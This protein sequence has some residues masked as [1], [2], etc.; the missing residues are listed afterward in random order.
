MCSS[1]REANLTS[2]HHLLRLLLFKKIAWKMGKK[3]YNWK[4]IHC[5]VTVFSATPYLVSHT[6]TSLLTSR[7]LIIKNK[8][9]FKA[10]N[11]LCL[12]KEYPSNGVLF[13]N[14]ICNMLGF[15]WTEQKQ[16]T[17][18]L[19]IDMRTL[20]AANMLSRFRALSNS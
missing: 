17:L 18:N 10:L 1:Y 11:C 7:Q 3:C 19:F 14:V 2:W 16:L 15:D 13:M 6:G 4:T 8:N 12:R 20:L 9:L 5:Y